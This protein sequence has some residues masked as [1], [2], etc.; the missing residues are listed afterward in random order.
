MLLNSYYL[1]TNAASRTL[2]MPGEGTTHFAFAKMKFV[3]SL[4][5]EI[6][7]LRYAVEMVQ[8]YTARLSDKRAIRS[9]LVDEW[10]RLGCER[11]WCGRVGWCGSVKEGELGGG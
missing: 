9:V 4:S 3:C 6:S 5:M 8:I 1:S 2:R 11:G 10:A 7:L